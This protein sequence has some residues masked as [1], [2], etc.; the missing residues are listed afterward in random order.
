MNYFN[1]LKGKGDSSERKAGLAAIR[2]VVG[3]LSSYRVT[4]VVVSL[5]SLVVSGIGLVQPYLM[6]RVFDAAILPGG[7]SQ[8]QGIILSILGL[9][10]FATVISYVHNILE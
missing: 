10:L 8:L 7:T 2:R 5:C 9:I 4:L 3:Y 6:G 1:F